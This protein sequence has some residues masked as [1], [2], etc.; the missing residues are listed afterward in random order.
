MGA[1]ATGAAPFARPTR[2]AT[3]SDAVSSAFFARVRGGGVSG[4][5][6][7]ARHRSRARPSPRSAR[8]ARP[9]TRAV[10]TD[11]R[12][13]S[14]AEKAGA[15]AGA[16][17]GGSAIASET[18][19][20]LDRLADGALGEKHA[21]CARWVVFSD[22][23]VNR[24]TAPVA[25]QV[26]RAVHEA[27]IERD[28]GIVFLGDFWH[29]RGAIP[30][31]PLVDALAEIAK[32]RVPAVMI[33]GNHDQVTAGGE[34]HALT[35]L[36]AANPEYVRVLSRPTLWRGALWLPY[37]RDAKTLREAVDA[38]K[39]FSAET[40]GAGAP[41]ED[42]ARGLQHGARGL[43]A[44]MCH[45]DVVGASMNES[46]QARDGIDPSVFGVAESPLGFGGGAGDA[47]ERKTV[48]TYTGH[49][50]K[51]HTVPGTRI[52]YVGSPYQVSRAE[53]GQTKA[54]V[55]LDAEKG[56]LGCEERFFEE[57]TTKDFADG[58]ERTTRDD[59]VVGA[60]FGGDA[61][62]TDLPARSLI[63]LNIGPRH[64]STR[65]EDGA[66][67]AEARAGD[68]V[69]WTLPLSSEVSL[70]AQTKKKKKGEPESAADAAS[71]AIASAR[72]RGVEVEITYEAVS[73][74]PRIPQAEEMGPTGLY[75]A[76]AS[77][78]GLPAEVADLGREVLADVAAAAARRADADGTSVAS[79]QMASGISG[80]RASHTNVSL[81]SVEVE[82][83]GAFAERATYPLFGRGVCAVVGDN[84][85][86]RCSDSN[87]AGKTTLV[88]APM[89]ALTGRTDA[90]VEDGT[91][92][93]LGKTDVVSDGSKT[94]R[95]ALRGEVN[96]V[97]FLVERA[98]TRARVT[99][100]AYSIGGEDMTLADARMTQAQMD[101]DLGA[102]TVARVA[103]HGQHTV[104][105]LLDANDAALKAALGELVEA[106]TWAAAKET[107]R[108]RVSEQRKALAAA[109][110]DVEAREAYVR[111][112]EERL[113]GATEARDAWDDDVRAKSARLE[114]AAADAEVDARAGAEKCAAARDRLRAASAAW[115]A[116]ER[117]VAATA[118]EAERR[119]W[120]PLASVPDGAGIGNEGGRDE[121]LLGGRTGDT[122]RAVAERA[123]ALEAD[124]ERLRAVAADARGAEAAARTVAAAA[125]GAVGAFQGLKSF[126]RRPPASASSAS[127]ASCAD[128]SHGEAR[129]EATETEETTETGAGSLGTCD[130]CLQPIDPAAH[131]EA[132]A[133]LVAEAE[134]A[135]RAHVAAAAASRAADAEAARATSLV[136]AHAAD[137]AAARE[138]ARRASEALAREARDAG[139]RLASVRARRVNPVVVAAALARLDAA[140]A[141]AAGAGGEGAPSED[142]L[143]PETF[144]TFE[145]FGSRPSLEPDGGSSAVAAAEDAA[146]E[147]ERLIRFADERRA[148]LRA[149]A[150]AS[151][152]NPRDAEVASLRAQVE[153]ETASLFGRRREVADAEETL[154]AL[155]RA[156]VAF[157]SR[158]IQSYLFEGALAELSARVAAYMDALTGGA[159]TL[160]LAPAAVGEKKNARKTRAK[161]PVVRT[162]SN[163]GSNDGS[164]DVH[165]TLV[166]EG[167]SDALVALTDASAADADADADGSAPSDDAE[168]WSGS[169]FGGASA[170]KIEKI[171]H[172]H[173]ADGA[174]ARRSL[175]QLSGGERRRAA[176]AL[177]LAHADL[178]A[179]RGGVHCDLL[180]LDEVLQ[181]LD[182]EGIARVAAALRAM[183][184]GTVLLTSQADSATSHL[185]DTVDRVWKRGGSAGVAPAGSGGLDAD[186]RRP[187][188]AR[189]EREGVA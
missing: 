18:E 157:G 170:E 9:L 162:T 6:H 69:R 172:A 30:V 70:S 92:K 106:D 31:E 87:G 64:F 189:L 183:P 17:A 26:L 167:S 54:L 90:R 163:D 130:R 73:A 188:E 55:V 158:G 143:R 140:C 108:K 24:K 138:A 174:R 165:A 84:G 19:A 83:F 100:L 20:V 53:A 185:F 35:P 22:L 148:D 186:V 95:V 94:A 96:G 21:L 91:S 161:K 131:A 61:A 80:S 154:Q 23:H 3:G 120:D 40:E 155:R 66:I 4:A 114:R 111:R 98:V 181:H 89:W 102:Q 48:P 178:A 38:A 27:A 139:E 65:G 113:K 109:R 57:T 50:H 153:A 133:R 146:A 171:V 37:R 97:S 126:S 77:A 43:R 125:H 25:M 99:R 33:P 67:P 12:S 177:A 105:A 182:A 88:M 93:S 62:V 187:A 28:A 78:V 52:T 36:Q 118:A 39:A 147:A 141:A 45:A 5:D 168:S 184:R 104:G 59:G 152:T 2:T 150:A 14:G 13:S 79:L 71:R 81:H 115:D 41:G 117:A 82:G 103:F 145:T 166:G 1:M 42:G 123:A 47:P 144:E 15:K 169:A 134:A 175:R 29:A 135:R 180:V 49:Y 85:D 176:L 101:R 68:L 136:R 159:L 164:N 107:S 156:D 86:D 34:T 179:S 124:A 72:A 151:S 74:P 32:W 160:A 46:F 121:E 16:K 8:G 119:M 128:A 51:P 149:A 11:S 112:A 56:W 127:S 75:D 7:A 63:P 142:L 10:A 60:D 122:E 116:E 129:G 76:Y 137:A 44:I 110:A 173:G 132:A 58:A